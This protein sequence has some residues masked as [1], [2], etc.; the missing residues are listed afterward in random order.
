MA[1]STKTVNMFLDHCWQEIFSLI[2][3]AAV[4]IDHTMAECLH[5][6]TGDKAYSVLKNVGAVSVH[7]IAMYNFSVKLFEFFTTKKP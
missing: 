5:W 3:N 2:Q 4:Y 6:Y 1:N 7:E